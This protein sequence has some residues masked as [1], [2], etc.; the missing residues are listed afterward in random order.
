[1]FSTD[2]EEEEE[3]KKDDDDDDKATSESYLFCYIMM[4][5]NYFLCF[6]I[7]DDLDGFS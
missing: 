1:M 7:S 4:I 5:T 6:F 2:R 3:K